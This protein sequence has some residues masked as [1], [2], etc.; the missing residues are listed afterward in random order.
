MGRRLDA[1]RRASS[2][3]PTGSRSCGGGG[4]RPGRADSGPIIWFIQ[5]A[6]D[7]EK[8][9]TRLERLAIL[10]VDEVVVAFDTVER[11]RDPA[12]AGSLR[13]GDRGERRMTAGRKRHRWPRIFIVSADGHF[14]EPTD[15]FVT[16]LPKHLRELAV[17][18]EDFEAEPL[19]GE[20]YPYFRK[21]HT[22]GFEGWTYMRY[23]HHDGS[24]QTGDPDRI[25]D[26]L[27]HEGIWATLLH[28]EPRAVRLVHARPPR[29]LDGARPR[30][31]RLRA[32]GVRALPRPRV[33]DVADPA[34]R[35]DDAVAE[36]ERVA[37][38]GSRAIILPAIVADP[39]HAR[40]R[41]TRCGRRHR[42]TACSS[43]ST[44][45]PAA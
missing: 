29:A 34:E 19:G 7:G 15:L 39:V 33:H 13:A 20:A 37:A 42:P 2:G 18:E 28:P 4:A 1:G 40:A 14:V 9:R 41:S 12:R 8:L 44:S 10:G 25:V 38:L 35:L 24:P 43:R 21:L 6:V 5:D 27:D 31:Q 26:D 17:W 23:R 32:R 3:S 16:R 36:V 22:P 30:V 11:E 45:R